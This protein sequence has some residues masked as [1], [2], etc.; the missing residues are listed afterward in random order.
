MQYRCINAFAYGDRVVAG[1]TLVD[2]GDPILESHPALFVA[3]AEPA[4]PG[5][6]TADTVVLRTSRRPGRPKKTP[7]PEES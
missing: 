6:E 7:E 1:G 2:E 3:V 4:A 5:T